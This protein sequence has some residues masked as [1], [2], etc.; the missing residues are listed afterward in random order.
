[1]KSGEICLILII[2]AFLSF[3]LMWPKLRGE[4]LRKNSIDHSEK[5][6]E[7]VVSTIC[8]PALAKALLVSNKYSGKS[9]FSALFLGF[10]NKLRGFLVQPFMSTSDPNVVI[11]QSMSSEF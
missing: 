2:F 9:L 5:K 1:M 6:L 8:N 10:S 11:L 3:P 4:F 7:G